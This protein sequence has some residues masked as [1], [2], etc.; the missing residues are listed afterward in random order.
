MFPIDESSQLNIFGFQKGFTHILHATYSWLRYLNKKKTIVWI[1]GY[2]ILYKNTLY[3]KI[4]IT[5]PYIKSA[6][7]S[8]FR[9]TLNALQK[10]FICE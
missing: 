2:V 9:Q 10:F 6:F 1:V 3:H 8:L 4:T 5:S 7:S